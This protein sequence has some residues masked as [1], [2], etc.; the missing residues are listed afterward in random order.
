M[1]VQ[2]L[3][4]KHKPGTGEKHLI[5]VPENTCAGKGWSAK[6]PAGWEQV[7]SMIT[8]ETSWFGSNRTE[9]RTRTQGGEKSE[10]VLLAFVSEK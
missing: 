8:G 4:W 9:R 2:A 7:S 10:S 3:K 1:C 5:D 6:Q